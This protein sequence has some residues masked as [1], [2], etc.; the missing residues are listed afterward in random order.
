MRLTR[1]N[2]PLALLLACGSAHA[3]P[4]LHNL[5]LLPGGTYSRGSALSADG[6]VVTGTADLNTD[7]L[8][9]DRAF[10]WTLST[11]MQSLGTPTGLPW[12]AANSM[13][14][15]G[16]A[17][18]G[19]AANRLFRWTSTGGMQNLGV[20]P[21]GTI[22]LATGISGDASIVVGWGNALGSFYGC[23]WTSSTGVQSLGAL[24]GGASSAAYAISRDGSLIAGTSEWTG[25]GTR[26]TLWPSVGSPFSIGVLGGGTNSFARAVSVNNLVVVGDSEHQNDVTWGTRMFRWTSA[27]GMQNLGVPSG[28]SDS[29]AFGV[30]ADGKVV[31]GRAK[32]G[33]NFRAAMWSTQVGM[34]DLT[35]HLASLGVNM[36]GW[37]LTDAWGVSDDGSAISGTGLFNGQN[38]AFLV[39]NVPCPSVPEYNDNP[40]NATTCEFSTEAVTL[41]VDADAPGT[42]TYQW[43]VEAPFS[44]DGWVQIQGPSYDDPTTGLSFH[45]DGWDGPDLAISE[46]ALATHPAAL[47]FH[48]V[49][50]N[51]CGSTPSTN[52]TITVGGDACTTCTADYNTDGTVDV[53][54]FLDFFDD[55]STCDGKAGPCGASGNADVNNDGTVDVLDFLDFLDAFSSG[56]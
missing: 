53:L 56:C 8:W 4:T 48:A 2:A 5:G 27:G 20:I 23:R 11:G 50:S 24:P 33:A 39:T 19:N 45:V 49:A 9:G 37:V 52:A 26:A 34:V 47:R 17:V 28:A 22:A 43:F 44:P 18:A 36:T 1:L 14:T 15:N 16:T 30:N 41:S 38:R 13:N 54:D 7:E 10:R 21:G 3:T 31:T 55:F 51:A 42:L 35:N 12:T 40:T 29:Y 6:T 25:P 46:I 32:H